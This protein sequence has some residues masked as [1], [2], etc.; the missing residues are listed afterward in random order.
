MEYETTVL[1]WVSVQPAINSLTFMH[2]LDVNRQ[3]SFISCVLSVQYIL[4]KYSLRTVLINV[5][6]WF[7]IVVIR[8]SCQRI[9]LLKFQEKTIGSQ[10]FDIINYPLFECFF[11]K[12]RWFIKQIPLELVN[13][14]ESE[15]H[16]NQIMLSC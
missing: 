8:L 11:L 13:I 14:A 6:F 12:S 1:L 7:H 15:M 10:Y 5:V 9:Q 2:Y 3:L 16:P 4:L